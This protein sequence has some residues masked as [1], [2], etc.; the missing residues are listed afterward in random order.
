MEVIP[1]TGSRL[2]VMLRTSVP[3]LPLLSQMPVATSSSALHLVES[4]PKRQQ[5]PSTPWS[6]GHAEGE[7]M[8]LFA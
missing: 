3:L 6:T 4:D 8:L 7:Q 1:E 5:K 2:V